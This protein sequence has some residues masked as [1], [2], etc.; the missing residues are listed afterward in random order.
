MKWNNQRKIA[1]GLLGLAIIAFVGDRL[2]SGDQESPES[3]I[4]AAN[5]SN[6]ATGDVRRDTAPSNRSASALPMAMLAD[7]MEEICLAEGLVPGTAHDVFRPPASWF[8]A[9]AVTPADTTVRAGRAADFRQKYKL[10]AVMRGS[11]GGLAVIQGET[12]RLGQ[13]I[14]G[15]KLIAIKDRSAVLSDGVED[16][17]LELPSMPVATVQ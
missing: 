8:P 9:P 1:S 16:V 4:I 2:L 15:L 14:G 10:T 5:S 3:L 13:T 6:G 11:S 7:R 17:E 12:V